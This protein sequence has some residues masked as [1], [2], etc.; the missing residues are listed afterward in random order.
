MKP[1][2][3]AIVA[4]L[5]TTFALGYGAHNAAESGRLNLV[6]TAQADPNGPVCSVGTLRGVYG[7]KFDG[8]WIGHGQ[9][10]SISKMTFDGKGQFETHEIGRLNGEPVD[11]TFTGPYTVNDDCTGFLDFSS[12]LTDPAHVAH[13]N[14]VI[15]DGGK[16]FFV[17]DNEDNWIADGVGRKL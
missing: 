1:T 16:G 14:F 9:F 3:I 11:R 8:E 6:P 10:S 13:G 2:P 15:V 7:I 5:A 4:A 12:N 17:V